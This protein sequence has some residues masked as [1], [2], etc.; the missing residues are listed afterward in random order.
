MD[1]AT[2]LR[3]QGRITVDSPAWGLLR[4]PRGGAGGTEGTTHRAREPE[5]SQN[6]EDVGN[7]SDL[8]QDAVCLWMVRRR[9]L[10]LSHHTW[11]LS[12]REEDG[13]LGSILELTFHVQNPTFLS[14]EE[15]DGQ[16]LSVGGFLSSRVGWVPKLQPGLPLGSAKAPEKSYKGWTWKDG[17]GEQWSGSLCP[18]L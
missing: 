10:G 5:A 15:G 14:R 9:S 17:G 12:M 11:Y 18:Q 4:G 8:E 3:T 1:K 2:S 7:R 13:Y 16:C 6:P